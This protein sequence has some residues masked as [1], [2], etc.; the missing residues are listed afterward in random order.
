MERGQGTG[1]STE[2][3]RP[4]ELMRLLTWLSPSFPVGAYTYSHGLEYAVE[5][6]RVHDRDTLFR[7]IEGILLFGA[8]RVDGGLFCQAHA[9]ARREDLAELF[10]I[11]VKADCWRGTSEMALESTAQ[12]RAFVSTVEKV[13]GEGLLSRWAAA[14]RADGR[15]PAYPIAVAIA[16]AE[17]GVSLTNGLIAYLHAV[18]ANLVSSAVRL[19]PLGQSD[20]VRVLARLEEVIA[21]ASAQAMAMDPEDLGA[22]APLVDWT[23]MQHETQY[24]RL[25]RS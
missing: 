23:S 1:M 9:A 10:A 22:C 16:S 20:G 19:V 21:R 4:S 14:L 17:I 8:G 13:W 6:G 12:G 15:L 5:D 2:A 18:A 3:L 24:T 11:G 25:F 7:W